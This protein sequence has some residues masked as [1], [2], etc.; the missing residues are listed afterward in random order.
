MSVT[1]K[2][3]VGVKALLH[4]IYD[5]PDPRPARRRGGARPVRPHR[6]RP[7]ER[8]PAV[9]ENVGHARADILAFTVFPKET[10][11]QTWSNRPMSA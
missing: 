4:S 10:W 9:A 3:S 2:T 6:R 11:R 8:L 1:A 5:Q 7:Y